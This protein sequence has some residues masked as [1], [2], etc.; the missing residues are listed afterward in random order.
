[1]AIFSPKMAMSMVDELA[2]KTHKEVVF[3]VLRAVVTRSP[4]DTGTY[5]SNH[6]VNETSYTKR[7]GSGDKE[8]NS[9]QAAQEA[10]D[11]GNSQ[12]AKIQTG[13]QSSTVSNSVPY[14][15]VIEHGSPNRPG[16]GV[17]RLAKKSV[18]DTL[19]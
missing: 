9:S 11:A 1:M 6:K 18:E 12:I 7:E 19:T 13:Y 17:Y 3:K 8:G 14:A 2:L 10:L 4:V 16:L 5:K 15:G